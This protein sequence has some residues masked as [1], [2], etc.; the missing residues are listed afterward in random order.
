MAFTCKLCGSNQHQILPKKDAKNGASLPISFCND[1]SLV[2]QTAIPTAEE[3][4]TYYSHN[5]RTDYKKT[6]SPKIKHVRRAGEA[7]LDRLA[8]LSNAMSLCQGKRLIDIGAGGGEFVY[9]ASKFGYSSIGIE[10]N[11]GYSAFSRQEYEVDI[12]TM[13]LDELGS[14]SAD[15]ITLFHVFE[16]MANP[17]AVMAK[18]YQILGEDGHL[19]IEVPNILQKD[20]APTN[21]FFKAHLYYYSRHTLE[22]AASRY[23]EVLKVEDR[24]NLKMLF[25]KRRDILDIPLLPHCKDVATSSKAI[26]SHGWMSY[27]FGGGG[28]SKPFRKLKQFLIE[29]QLDS[30]SPK[31]LLDTLA[32]KRRQ[33]GSRTQP[34]LTLAAALLPLAI[35]E[36]EC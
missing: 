34:I 22:A 14:E 24:S 1:C 31:L 2:Q 16:H 11:H 35:L 8:F 23:F 20:A 3:L 32:Q 7:A 30:A 13:S 6:Y 21:I 10:P 18:L 15:I 19:F 25:R 33:L 27:L 36:C 26:S 4:K 17:H 28:I 9:M 29:S 5:Y 12:K